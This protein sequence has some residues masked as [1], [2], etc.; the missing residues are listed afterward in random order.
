[1]KD[2]G[3]FS[4]KMIDR[5]V[6]HGINWNYKGL[7]MDDTPPLPYKCQYCQGKMYKYRMKGNVVVA[8]CHGEGCPNNP[9]TDWKYPVN[10]HTQRAVMRPE[11]HWSP[12]PPLI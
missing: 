4:L 11:L 8:A 3:R 9:D 10:H 1:M 5:N 12:P 2:Y 6:P 7:H